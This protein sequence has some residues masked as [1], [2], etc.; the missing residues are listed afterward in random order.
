MYR[1]EKI[2]EWNMC[3]GICVK[4]FEASKMLLVCIFP[5][6][7]NLLPCIGSV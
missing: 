2:T 7:I 6:K 1:N 3:K 4:H 5:V